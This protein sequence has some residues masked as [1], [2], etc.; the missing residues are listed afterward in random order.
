AATVGYAAATGTLA[1]AARFNGPKGDFGYDLDVNPSGTRLNV[2]GT[3]FRQGRGFD[4]LIPTYNA[5]T[6]GGPFLSSYHGPGNG[7]DLAVALAVSSTS[8]VFVTGS[9]G[10]VGTAND[11]ATVG[12]TG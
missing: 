5:S 1:W 7:H 3:T 4:Y 12:R 8:G 11:F 6:G 10:G 2:A 9:S